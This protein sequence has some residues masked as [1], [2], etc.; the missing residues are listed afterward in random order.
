MAVVASWYYNIGEVKFWRGNESWSF[1]KSKEQPMEDIQ[2]VD[3]STTAVTTETP[4]FGTA[5]NEI[6]R[7]SEYAITENKLYNINYISNTDTSYYDDNKYSTYIKKTAN[8]W[9]VNNHENEWIDK[10]TLIEYEAYAHGD[11]RYPA[12]WSRPFTSPGERMRQILASRSA[13][14]IG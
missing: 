5:L 9:F 4:A 3:Y 7:P 1:L 6:I 13:P 10:K 11:P 2:M 8:Q 12:T 14:A